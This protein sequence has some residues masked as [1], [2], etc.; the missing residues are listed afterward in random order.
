MGGGREEGAISRVDWLLISLTGFEGLEHPYKLNLLQSG[1]IA[2][3][4]EVQEAFTKE[5]PAKNA[6]DGIQPPSQA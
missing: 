1:R 5:I 6:R 3:L 4:P 2:Q